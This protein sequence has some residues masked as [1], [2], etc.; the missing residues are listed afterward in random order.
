MVGELGT[1]PT[2]HLPPVVWA[3]LSRAGL[4]I[5]IFFIC[6]MSP[7]AEEAVGGGRCPGVMKNRGDFS[8][9]KKR[10]LSTI[11]MPGTR[12]SMLEAF[13]LIQVQP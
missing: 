10:L 13:P 9:L 5:L 11:P 1:P 6:R 7:G 2:P 4:W 8:K 3:H 12:L